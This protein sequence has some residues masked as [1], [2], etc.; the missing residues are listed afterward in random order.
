MTGFFRGIRRS[1]SLGV[2]LGSSS[3]KIVEL[4]RKKISLAALLEIPPAERVEEAALIRRLKGFFQEIGI[5][6]REAVIY[7]PGSYSFIRTIFFPSM[8]DSEL[9]EAIRWEIKRQIPY[10]EEEAVSDY[11]S[12]EVPEGIAATI[13]AA[14]RKNIQK[15]ISIFKEAGFKV[16]AVDVSPLALLRVFAPKDNNNI[17]LIDIGAKHI[18]IDIIKAGVIRLTRTVD[19]GGEFVINYLMSKG[20]SLEDAGK[21]L[22]HAVSDEIKEPLDQLLREIVRSIDYYKANF[23][24][25]VFTRILFTGGLSLNSHISNYFSKSLGIPVSVPNPFEGY[26]LKDESIRVLGPRF[27]V[28][29]GLARRLD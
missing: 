24:E 12:Q 17:L 16:I 26:A 7:I 6:D 9:K 10:S 11:I 4:S 19:M 28:A 13:A 22:M 14:E 5:T 20:V 8:P 2:D 3:L 29:V 23:K 18:E 1:K 15:Q 25:K 27:S 21:T